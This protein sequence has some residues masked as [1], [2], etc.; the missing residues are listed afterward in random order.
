MNPDE[1]WR[2]LVEES[3]AAR[4]A[5]DGALAPVLRKQAAIAAGT[6]RENSSPEE[7]ARLLAARDV[8]NDVNTQIEEFIAENV[9]RR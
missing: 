4:K 5:L 6:A 3:H 8:W 7:D 9:G 2:Q 1:K